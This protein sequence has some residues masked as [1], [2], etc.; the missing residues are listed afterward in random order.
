MVK[1][2]N[3][4]FFDNK[5]R[6]MYYILGTSYSA[7]A[8]PLHH[9]D[10]ILFRN[11]DEKLVKIIRNELQSDHEIIPDN[12]GKSSYFF[13][14]TSSQMRSKL[15]NI[16]LKQDK[17]ERQFPDDIP[18]EYV[19]HF[20]RGFFDAGVYIIPNWNNELTTSCRLSFYKLF[21]EG[22]GNK[23]NSFLELKNKEFN[24]YKNT[25]KTFFILYGHKDSLKIHDF[26]YRD[27][28]YVKEHNLYL[29]SKKDLFNIDYKGEKPGIKKGSH[30]KKVLEKIEAAKKLLLEGDKVKDVAEKTGYGSSIAFYIT[31][32]SITGKSP[33]EFIRS[34][35]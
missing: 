19:S 29:A 17:A 3:E 6:E 26:I 4:Y 22:L 9:K 21:L 31:F 14:F 16:G 8:P 34:K 10:T 27:F 32:K 25:G 13:N 24:I 2:V 23:L 20:I 11:S 1:L 12:R 35:Q 5:S 28:E 15:N 30:Q 18:E 7:Y 33:K